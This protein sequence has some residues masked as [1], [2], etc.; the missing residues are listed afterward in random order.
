MITR[1]E[2]NGWT[3]YETW[4]I[5]LEVIDG[6]TLEDFGF[7]LHDVDTDDVADVERLAHAIES[8]VVD[9]VMVGGNELA[10][11]L[12]EHFLIQVDWVELAEHIISDAREG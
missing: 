11:N 4:R 9:S 10:L 8:H 3:N 2:Y 6:M 12:L 1:N 5:N 7:D